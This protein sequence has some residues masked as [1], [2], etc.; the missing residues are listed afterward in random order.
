MAT[1]KLSEDLG[2]VK[3]EE[4]ES[5]DDYLSGMA[6]TLSDPRMLRHRDADVR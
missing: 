1:Q 3:Q 6:N 2:D 4:R 5:L